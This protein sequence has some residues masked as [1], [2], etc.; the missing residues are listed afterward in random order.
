MKK[1]LSI[2][3]NK[4]LLTIVAFGVWMTF[5]DQNDF[6]AQRERKQEWASVKDNITYLEK[7]I[8]RLETDK[9][10]IQNNPASLEKF[11]REQYRMKRDNEDVYV[12]Q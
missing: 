7:E 12:I 6:F 9:D 2:V 8:K 4:F 1:V 10:Q 5:F 3:T 11:A